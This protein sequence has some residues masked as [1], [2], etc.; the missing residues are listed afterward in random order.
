MV[1]LADQR[2]AFNL[3]M[4]PLTQLIASVT[5]HVMESA[6]FVVTAPDDE[7]WVSPGLEGHPATRA[8][9]LDV[10]PGKEP[11]TMKEELDVGVEDGFVVEEL[12]GEPVT[13][14][15]RI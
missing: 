12:P 11:F 13:G 9:Y 7:H 5:A 1:I 4:A 15:S 6:D 8:W 10:V 3:A 14:W 2:F